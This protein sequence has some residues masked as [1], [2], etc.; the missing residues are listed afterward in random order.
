MQQI[1][2]K[3]HPSIKGVM[4]IDGK[5]NFPISWLNKQ[6]YCEYS[7]YL[8][9]VRGIETEPTI[10]MKQGQAIH[11]EL[12]NEFKKGAEVIEFKEMMVFSQTQEVLS[13]EMFVSS[14]KFGIR[15]L[16]D[17]IWLTPDEFIIID[18]KP[19]S[20]AYNSSINQVWGY[21]LAFKDIIGSDDRKIMGALRQRGSSKIF[22]MQ[23]FNE[24]A[25]KTIQKLLDR[26]Q[27]LF[28]GSKHF[29]PTNNPRKCAKCRFNRFCEFG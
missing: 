12:E 26:M 21:C 11:Q 22:W 4:I 1:D 18:D 23:E 28:N 29:L 17:E 15:G 13:R 10:E 20:I 5:N 16:I 27:D 24:N 8:E 7:I 2:A 3:P 19:G 9:N 25:Q 14:P 6:G